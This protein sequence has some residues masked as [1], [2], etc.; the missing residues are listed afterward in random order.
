[1]LSLP[2]QCQQSPHLFS[3]GRALK[4]EC[5]LWEQHLPCTSSAAPEAQHL[6]ALPGPAISFLDLTARES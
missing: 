6:Q 4:M 2:V 3:S 5:E 1:M